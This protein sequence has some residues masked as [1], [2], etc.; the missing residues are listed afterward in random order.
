MKKIILGIHL[1]VVIFILNGCNTNSGIESI[2]LNKSNNTID[3]I[4][5]QIENMTL[6]E[7]IGQMITVG[8]DGY[9]LNDKTK[10]LIEEKKVGGVILFKDNIKDSN[11][12]LK[13]ILRLV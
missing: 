4:Q 13:L 6:D 1:L 7:K 12:L 9:T 2:N 10:L 5:K 8:L 3:L 11:Q